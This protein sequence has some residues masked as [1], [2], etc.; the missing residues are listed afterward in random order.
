M[1]GKKKETY[2]K[3]L[4]LS[5]WVGGAKGS[6]KKTAGERE[7]RKKEWNT[8]R[9]GAKKR[10]SRRHGG[11]RSETCGSCWSKKGRLTRLRRLKRPGRSES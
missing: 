8:G 4:E 6:L 1:N 2:G 9:G 3:N 7:C 5:G 10:K 11:R